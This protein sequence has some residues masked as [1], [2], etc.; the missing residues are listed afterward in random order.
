MEQG[1]VQAKVYSFDNKKFVL[2]E[3]I[4]NYLFLVNMKNSHDMMIRKESVEKPNV[5]LP[6]DDDD[7]FE[8][9]L[10]LLTR[11]KLEEEEEI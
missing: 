3:Q 7:E 8:H 5:L 2:V 4:N 6:L 10:Q 11:K 9:A 1:V